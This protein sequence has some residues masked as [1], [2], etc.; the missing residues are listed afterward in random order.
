[1]WRVCAVR[2]SMVSALWRSLSRC[3]VFGT[4][5]PFSRS[6]VDVTRVT[7]RPL[8][9]NFLSVPYKLDPSLQ[10]RTPGLGFPGLSSTHTSGRPR[11]LAGPSGPASTMLHGRARAYHGVGYATNFTFS[12]KSASPLQLNRT[13]PKSNLSA[14]RFCRGL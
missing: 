2:H 12:L 14:E 5:S 13:Q 8:T 1:M 3:G 4:R 11:V 6:C 7:N 10:Y 9:P